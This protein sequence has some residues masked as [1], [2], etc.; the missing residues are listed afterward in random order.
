MIGWVAPGPA[1][2]RLR[3]DSVRISNIWGR[4]PGS[5]FLPKTSK[6]ENLSLVNCTSLDSVRDVLSTNKDPQVSH[7][8]RCSLAFRFSDLL[9]FTTLGFITQDILR[10]IE[11]LITRILRSSDAK[12]SGKGTHMCSHTYPSMFSNQAL[13]SSKP[14]VWISQV[15]ILYGLQVMWDRHH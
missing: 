8:L 11:L 7:R 2:S 15:L 5:S 4:H 14:I 6:A 9:H 13:S 1:K 10:Y 12:I 3:L